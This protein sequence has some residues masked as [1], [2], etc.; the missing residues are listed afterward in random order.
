M[1]K[2]KTNAV[3][4]SISSALSVAAVVFVF[5]VFFPQN[6]SAHG[7]RRIAHPRPAQHH[8]HEYDTA[9]IQQELEHAVESPSAP[10]V[11]F[12]R[13][14]SSDGLLKVY[15]A[16]GQKI[17]G[18]VGIKV[19]FGGPGEQVINPELLSG[20]IEKT[21]GTLID[22]NGLSGNR[23]TSAKNYK[24]AEA[25]GFSKVGEVLM[26]DG[27]DL[28]MPVRGGH[29]LKFART[30]NQFSQFSTMIAVHRFKLHCIEALGGNIKNIS[31]CLANRSGKC[32]IHSGGAD[33]NSYHHTEHHVLAKSF[34]D[35]AK[36]ALDYRENW[37]FINVVDSFRPD[38]RCHGAE[39]VGDIGIIA[40]NDVVALDQCALDLY[41]SHSSATA[42]Q[43]RAWCEFH[44]T[45]VLEYCE[46]I[47]IGNRQYRFV[48]LD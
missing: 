2:I 22:G 37:A 45:D 38:D 24:L 44:Q 11:Y 28:D 32:L 35:A 10:A 6:V 14:I 15:N 4:I 18:K 34:A 30:G 3:L 27:D 31:L 21:G 19:S 26:L 8:A 13:D 36:A 33:P 20:L 12:T 7:F 41:L 40:S 47:G 5:L 1:K 39:N 23:R 17:E 43:K 29:H 42:E 16:L 25:H 9:R 46:N 48:N